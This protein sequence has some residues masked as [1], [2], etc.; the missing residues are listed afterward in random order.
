MFY[1]FEGNT[2]EY[3]KIRGHIYFT[4]PT[5]KIKTPI[6]PGFVY[7]IYN[8][9]NNYQDVFFHK[10][11]YYLFINRI[12]FYLLEYCSI[13][14]YALLPNHYHFLIRVNED[15]KNFKFSRQFGKSIVSYTNIINKKYNRNGNLFLRCFRRIKIDN[16][17]Y[18][19]RLVYYIHNNPSKHNIAE[20]FRIFEFSS[21][22]ALLSDSPTC[23]CN[24]TVFSL[25][26]S[27][28]NFIEYHEYLDS[29]IFIKKLTFEED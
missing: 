29:E 28:D 26:G 18:L 21:Y 17:D 11:D 10:E 15:I 13:Y 8:R 7:H 5:K 2:F 24:N 22:R 20:D 25:F 12:K 19:K 14:A 9:G 6:E 4:M 27:K 1:V 23:I 16:E 3:L